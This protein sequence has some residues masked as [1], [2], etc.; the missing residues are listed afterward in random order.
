MTLDVQGIYL[1][2]LNYY[3]RS[4]CTPDGT[5][6]PYPTCQ[7][8]IRETRDGCDDCPGPFGGPRNREKEG[9]NS[10]NGNGGKRKNGNSGGRK[11]QSNGRNHAEASRRSGNGGNRKN[12]VNG[13]SRRN[14]GNGGNRRN[15]AGK[16]V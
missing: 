13:G 12:G 4:L 14:Q 2:F 11:S 9:G 5:W 1:N 7:G 10:G 6:D 15:Q 3:C 8:D 16:K